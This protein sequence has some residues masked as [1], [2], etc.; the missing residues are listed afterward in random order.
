MKIRIEKD[1]AQADA[2]THGGVFHADDVFAT[3]I[4]GK[5]FGEF[6]LC[7]VNRMPERYNENAVIYDIG[8]GE[9]DHHQ[10]GG[11]G[12]RENG[13][14]YAAAGLVWKKYGIQLTENTEEPEFIWNWMDQKLFQG[15]DAIDNGALPRA[16][17][18]AQSMSLSEVVHYY[19]VNWDEN[20]SPD[21]GFLK[22]VDF[23]ENVFDLVYRN[24]VS[25]SRAAAIVR[26]AVSESE[27]NIMILE[28]YV[29]WQEPLF[30]DKSPKAEKIHF[31]VYP[32]IRGGYN[33]Q[34]V[35]KALGSFDQRKPVPFS[36]R[37]LGD[38]KLRE[39]T[40]V[41]TAVFCHKEG[42]IGAAE[43]FE[44]AYRMALLAE[45][46]IEEKQ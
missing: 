20:D 8:H 42:F 12:A 13:V 44:D 2:I 31:V 17:Y 4:L 11:N 39:I 34:C 29:P 45:R 7:R 10:P 37:G 9:L 3:V 15:I 26:A 28:K 16:D 30:A 19:N 32:S 46:S 25:R 43:T 38:G 36:W 40:G 5:R 27:N 1:P 35:P 6:S 18:P 23:A 21:S 41:E 24:A 33:W 14:P 22:A